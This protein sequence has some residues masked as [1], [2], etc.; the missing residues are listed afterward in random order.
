MET[1]PK[2][3]DNAE[4]TD[5]MGV[6][7]M[8]A[9]RWV[10]FAILAVAYLF[11]YFHRLSMSVVAED[12]AAD[13]KVSGKILGDLGSIYFYCY[14]I[15][16]FP[17]GLLSDSVG[18]RK[19]VTIFL[20]LAA[21]GSFLFGLAGRI[22]IAFLSRIMVGVGVSMV[23]IPTMKIL[24]QWFRTGE[25]ALMSGILNA[26]GGAGV[27]SG[28]WILGLMAS[29]FGWRLSFEWIGGCTV[30]LILLVW[31]IVRDNPAKK[32]WPSII[33]IDP[34]SPPT[35]A[36]ATI[37]LWE[38]VWKVV[39]KRHFWPIAVWFFFDC[40]IFFG[41][42]GLWGGPYLM[43][44]YGMTKPQAGAVLSMIAWGMI[45][46]SPLLGLLSEKVLKSRKKTIF[47]C[48]STLAVLLLL[49]WVCPSG[50]PEAAL[51]VWFFLFS[52]SSSAIV[53]MGFTATKE[54][55]PVEIAGTCVGTVNLFPFFGGAVFMSFLGR[56]LDAYGK[57]N[58]EQYP[59][60]AYRTVFFVLFASALV[61]L[62][63]IFLMK[64]T[65][66]SRKVID[67]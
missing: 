65:H 52:V 27:L 11:V 44:T 15:M 39:S 4:P 38:G 14:A 26:M 12:V 33:Q 18:P 16:Q 32:G 37:G 28:T 13:F 49:L 58:S 36:T 61:C 9:Y 25:F 2:T 8:L 20:I 62:V 17:A 10:I 64:E 55:F 31:L 22:E 46:G 57:N 34:Q 30:L 6:R 1:Y 59:L 19:S 43:H 54:L 47:L 40:G 67:P 7:K 51:Y 60:G 35:K 50:L 5:E 23:F 29:R 21:I 45:V 56:I 24:A 53:I 63:C 42:G 41:F 48:T 3:V 66:H